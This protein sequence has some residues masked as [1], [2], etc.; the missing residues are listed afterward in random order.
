MGV[1]WLGWDDFSGGYYVGERSADQPRDTWT[2]DNI[3]ID[4]NT[5][6]LMPM[7]S[8]Q[9][10]TSVTYTD[11][12]DDQDRTTYPVKIAT[13]GVEAS[14]VW[15]QY[16]TALAW[17]FWNWDQA[18]NVVR[19]SAA[20]V[21]L[22]SV[23]EWVGAIPTLAVDTNTLYA[24]FG[25]TGATMYRLTPVS[26][27]PPTFTTQAVG[28]MLTRQALWNNRM[29]TWAP[30]SSTSGWNKLYYSEASSFGAAGSWP[31]TNFYEIGDNMPILTVVVTPQALLI[32][33]RTGWWELRGTLGTTAAVTQIVTSAGPIIEH[34]V[35]TP[36]GSVLYDGA[37]AGVAFLQLQGIRVS[38]ANSRAATLSQQST[39]PNGQNFV[40]VSSPSALY[41]GDAPFDGAGWIY[42]GLRNRWARYTVTGALATTIPDGTVRWAWDFQGTYNP[43]STHY[44][45]QIY[46]LHI[47][48][49]GQNQIVTFYGG[50]TAPEIPFDREAT[51]TLAEHNS[52]P[53]SLERVAEVI[54]EVVAPDTAADYDG[55]EV[56]TRVQAFGVPDVANAMDPEPFS[57][58][59]FWEQHGDV[60]ADGARFLIR[61][62]PTNLP[63]ATGFRPEITLKNCKLRR[64]LL[65]IERTG[66]VTS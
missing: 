27:G 44:P 17:R 58:A 22:A 31:T 59:H 35:R 45:D 40:R 8:V 66:G 63:A 28:S 24:W 43:S 49:G 61:F 26:G 46:G 38:P 13:S 11:V 32:G 19:K 50:L 2:G 14:V 20:T 42:D 37:A 51:V 30:T 53:G 48:A 18:T 55:I 6:Y 41:I 47:G 1:T 7:P 4:P 62:R 65:A 16:E 36:N 60:I 33:K 10:V 15:A 57:D 54:V 5:G 25:A 9:A 23:D 12:P 29:V 56:T 39:G 34:A 52:P 64:V 21:N 3:W